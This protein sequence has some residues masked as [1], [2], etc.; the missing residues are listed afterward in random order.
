MNEKIA[1]SL[2]KRATGYTQ[3][4]VKEEYQKD[5]NGEMSLVK[6]TVTSK[7]Y[8]P[9]G[10]AVKSYLDMSETFEAA[11]LDDK[12]LAAEKERL[13]K[14]LKEREEKRGTVKRN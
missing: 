5:E 6:R 14:M 9:D 11:K 7:Y 3:D 4:E 13:L 1:R 10:A 12:T 8:P 2:L